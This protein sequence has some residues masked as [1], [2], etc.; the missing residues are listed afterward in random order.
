MKTRL[1]AALASLLLLAAPA[2]AGGDGWLTNLEEAKKKAKAEKKDI[3]IDFTGSDWCGWCIRLKKEVWSTPKWTEEGPK[4]YILVELDFPR[5]TPQSAEIK[6]YNA[7]LQAEFGVRGFPTIALLDS[8]GRPYGMTG[9]QKGGPEAYLS[10]LAELGKQKAQIA[11]MVAAAE[12]ADAKAI[13]E[14]LTKLARWRVAFGYRNLQEK[15]VS[16]DPKNEAGL[17]L[18]YAKQ[19]AGIYSAKK[20]EAK[21]KQYLEAVRSIDPKAATALEG[22]IKAT[23]LTS[24]LEAALGPLAKKNDWAGALKMLQT[25]YVPKHTEGAMGQTVKFFVA[26]CKFR[27]GDKPGGVTDLKAAK[28]MAPDSKLSVQIGKILQKVGG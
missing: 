5:R 11:E 10:H 20:N 8:E 3:L 9:Y 16:L 21:F 17:G 4:K 7:A 1:T 28:A 22:D 27:S 6:K 24:E 25:D 2:F 26:I 23:A 19:L 14:T 13:D 18:K 15:I 12:K